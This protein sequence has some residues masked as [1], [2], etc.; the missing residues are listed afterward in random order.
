M[1]WFDVQVAGSED[2][3]VRGRAVA[4]WRLTARVEGYV[5]TF[6][7]S[8]ESRQLLKVESDNGTWTIP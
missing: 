7:I 5:D 1:F 6:W 2:V 8:R 3:Q 4:A